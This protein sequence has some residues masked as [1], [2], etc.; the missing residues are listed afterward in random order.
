MNR[1]FLALGFV[2]AVTASAACGDDGSRGDDD[3]D[4]SGS[5]SGTGATT[6]RATSS[7]SGGKSSSSGGSSSSSGG[8]SSSSSS[9]G[10][11]SSSSGGAGTLAES[12]EAIYTTATSLDCGDE[13]PHEMYVQNCVDEAQQKDGACVEPYTADAACRAALGADAYECVNQQALVKE[14]ECQ[15]TGDALNECI[16]Q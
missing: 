1:I 2:L 4:E 11:S 9:S 6:G 13:Y 7:S 10:G 12:C 16:L 15:D 5:S 3:D 8:S 14:G